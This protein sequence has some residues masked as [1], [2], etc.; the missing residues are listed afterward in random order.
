M[1]IIDR[2]HWHRLDRMHRWADT[3]R[4]D[5]RGLLVEDQRIQPQI[6]RATDAL[7]HVTGAIE[8][9]QWVLDPNG[10]QE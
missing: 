7:D 9:A 1:D 2:D 4:A 3:L 5:L 8:D 10:E 6:D